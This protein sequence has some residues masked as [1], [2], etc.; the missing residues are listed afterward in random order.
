MLPPSPWFCS[1]L[2]VILEELL[3]NLYYLLVVCCI[4]VAMKIWSRPRWCFPLHVVPREIPA[5]TEDCVCRICQENS[6]DLLGVF[7]DCKGSVAL[8]HQRCLQR[9]V[10]VAGRDCCE[11]CL[12][13]FSQEE[14]GLLMQ[15]LQKVQ[16]WASDG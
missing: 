6:G 11:L 12:S 15:W 1:L 16:E 10:D 7:C 5:V 9:W 13:C 2:V 3:L 14:A 4:L 8:M